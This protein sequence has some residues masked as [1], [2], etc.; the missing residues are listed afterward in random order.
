VRTR[1]LNSICQKA[2]QEVCS[3]VQ[4]FSPITPGKGSLD[5]QSVDDNEWYVRLYHS[6]GMYMARHSE[7]C[8]IRQEEQYHINSTMARGT[9]PH[10]Q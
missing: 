2:V 1:N 10:E 6:A 3:N 8:A 4:F 9:V 5:K 7:L